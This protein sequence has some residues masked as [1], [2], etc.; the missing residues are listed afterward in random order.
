MAPSVLVGTL[1]GILVGA[2]AFGCADRTNAFPALSTTGEL[3][4][5][6]GGECGAV[7]VSATRA[8]TSAHCVRGGGPVYYHAPGEAEGRRVGRVWIDEKM[9]AACLE[10]ETRSA[11][12]EVATAT[13]GEDVVLEG[14]VTGVSAGTATDDRHA[15][16]RAQQGDSGSAVRSTA[17]GAVV[18]VLWGSPTVGA[19][20]DERVIFTPAELA[21]T[22][23]AE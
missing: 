13:T 19:Q 4:S 6:G 3:Q 12:S 10:V 17:T 16:L 9:S 20:S 5:D 2:S 8:L 1:V 11:P 14:N 22:L 23:C 18:G 15:D 7:V 21:V